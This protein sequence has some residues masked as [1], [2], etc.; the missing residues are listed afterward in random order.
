AAANRRIQ[1]S[2]TLTVKAEGHLDKDEID[3]AIT[4][5]RAALVQNPK[6][7][8]AESGLG[9]A[10]TA[11]GVQVAGDTNNEAAI[12][13]FDEAIKLDSLNAV[14]FAKLGAIYDSKKQNDKAVFNYE[15]A[16]ALEPERTTLQST[17]VHAYIDKGEIA[18]PETLLQKAEESGS[19]TVE[20]RY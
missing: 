2:N 20:T 17:L 12:P 8:R 19:D 9:E 18:K 3:E 4:D 15:K 16:L 11:K 6:N 5:F 13:Y 10:L 14:S 7:S 1:L